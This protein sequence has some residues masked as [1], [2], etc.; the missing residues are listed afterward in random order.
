MRII[1]TIIFCAGMV[2]YSSTMARASVNN[3]QTGGLSN[4]PDATLIEK[5]QNRFE[6]GPQTLSLEL[7][8]AGSVSVKNFPKLASV[9]FLTESN[10]LQFNVPAFED[11]SVQNCKDLGYTKTSCS[12]G[13]P[14]VFCPYNNAY[15]KECCDAAYK[16][17]AD[18]CTYPN[19][20]SKTSCGGKYQCT[21][22]T[23]LYPVTSCTSPQTPATGNGSSCTANGVTRYSECVCPSNYTETCTGQNQ[24]G[25]GTGCTYKGTTKYTACECKPGYNQTCTELGPVTPNDYCLMNGIRYYNNCKSCENKCKLDSCPAGVSCTLED[26]SGKYCDVGCATGYVNWCTKPETD[27]AKLGYTKSVSQ[28]SDGYLKCPYNS[29]AVFCEDIGAAVAVGDIL[30]GDGTV[31]NSLVAGKTPIGIV[32]DTTNHLAVALTDINSSGSAGSSTMYWSTSYYDIPAL[33][34]CTSSTDLM[35]CGVDGRANTTAILNCGSSCGSTPAATATNSYEPS[36][37]SKDFCKKTKWFLPSMRDLITLYNAKSYVN[38]SLSLTASSGAKTLTKSYYW[39]S[40]EFS[41]NYAWYLWMDDVSRYY[42]TKDYSEYVRPVVK[43]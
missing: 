12:S 10:S 16:Y 8:D 37:C 27:C 18:S 17:T 41:S 29:A 1:R 30:Y 15:F 7:P 19:T 25:R 21:C 22:D 31:A 42:G 38:A 28:C 36:G 5:N 3:N 9:H 6:F 14:S 40:T 32:F 39:S 4:N 43:Y 24:Q 23:T 35:T 11:T 2:V 26:C 34:N 33:G 20:I 13:N